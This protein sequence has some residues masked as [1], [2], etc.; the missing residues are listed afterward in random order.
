MKNYHRSINDNFIDATNQ[1]L[2]DISKIPTCFSFSIGGKFIPNELQYTDIGKDYKLFS[3]KFNDEFNYI[4]I[5]YISNNIIESILKELHF[6][7]VEKID[8]SNI[9]NAKSFIDNS[10][11]ILNKK[12]YFKHKNDNY[13]N[14]YYIHKNEEKLFFNQFDDNNIILKGRGHIHLQIIDDSNREYYKIIFKPFYNFYNLKIY[15][16]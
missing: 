2:L 14:H 5:H 7:Y 8:V 6:K 11:L 10:I 15:T 1:K 16:F 12:E 13:L 4:N 9:Y 3:S